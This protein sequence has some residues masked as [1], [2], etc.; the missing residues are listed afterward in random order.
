MKIDDGAEDATLEAPVAQ[1]SEPQ[2]LEV[3]G[4]PTAPTY[5]CPKPRRKLCAVRG[6]R[7]SVVGA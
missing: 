5:P 7:S 6:R 2:A 4:G 3:S 1:F